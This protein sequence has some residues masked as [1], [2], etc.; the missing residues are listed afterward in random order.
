MWDSYVHFLQ[1]YEYVP[2]RELH[3]KCL[4]QGQICIGAIVFRDD[5]DA[6]FLK[7]SSLPECEWKPN[8]HT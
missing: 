1:G 2:E 4:M 5:A 3:I 6:G 7:P 8:K